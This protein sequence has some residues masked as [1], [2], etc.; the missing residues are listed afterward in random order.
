MI[1]KTERNLLNIESENFQY[2]RDTQ[3]MG[4]TLVEVMIAMFLFLIGILAYF[5]LQLTAIR[6]NEVNKQLM[7]AQDVVSQ[8][9]EMVKTIG[10]T[11]IRTNS[12][13]TSSSF[14]YSSTLTALPAVYQ[15]SGINTTCNAPASYCVYKGL[16][17]TKKIN[18][19]PVNYR[20]TLK[21]SINPNYLTYPAL[22]EVD[23][24]LYWKIGE[25]LKNMSIA[26]F[27]GI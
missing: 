16:A 17:V 11:G 2:C 26:A 22:A 10:Y 21:L 5:Q 9:L 18:G 13:L 4:F 15:L 24:I 1:N 20:Y 14:S 6:M 19:S 7:V 12:T 23:A 25:S 8:E 3:I 27:V